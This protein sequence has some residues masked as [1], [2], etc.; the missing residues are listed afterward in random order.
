MESAPKVREAPGADG[1]SLGA[2]NIEVDRS[3]PRPSDDAGGLLWDRVMCGAG[4]GAPGSAAPGDM[5]LALGSSSA[6]GLGVF[7]RLLLGSPSFSPSL[8]DWR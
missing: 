4:I 5:T 1:T 2:V 3:S 6:M 8:N 7:G